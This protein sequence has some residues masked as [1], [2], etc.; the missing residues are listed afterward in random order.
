M[1]VRQYVYLCTPFHPG[2][3]YFAFATIWRMGVVLP[4]KGGGVF[5]KMF[6]YNRGY[7]ILYHGCLQS[8]KLDQ[9]HNNTLYLCTSFDPGVPY[10][11]FA[12][13]S[14]MGGVLASFKGGLHK[15]VC[16]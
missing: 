5:I 14:R 7:T 9:S 16:F 2:V 10:F 8:R 4:L 12:T 6:V 1:T 15:S 3:P 13:A 11:A